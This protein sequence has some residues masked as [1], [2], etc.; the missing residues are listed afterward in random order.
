MRP[1]ETEGCGLWLVM[2]M[3]RSTARSFIGLWETH[4]DKP[5]KKKQHAIFHRNTLLIFLIIACHSNQK[6]VCTNSWGL[7]RSCQKGH[8]DNRSPI[9]HLY[10]TRVK[11][12][13]EWPRVKSKRIISPAILRK[14]H[15]I[16]KNTNIL[17]Q[18]HD[19]LMLEI[20]WIKSSRYPVI[21]VTRKTFYNEKGN[22][23]QPE[24]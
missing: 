10:L 23:Y 14:M 5:L 21:K 22:Q 16:I 11:E 2:Q 6:H 18:D 8:M 12:C 7:Q 19:A 24:V 13:K 17:L 4:S 1:L 20:I 3:K 15:S 9:S